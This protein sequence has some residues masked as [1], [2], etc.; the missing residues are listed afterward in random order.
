[1]LLVLWEVTGRFLRSGKF[2]AEL[3]IYEIKIADVPPSNDSN[4][5]SFTCRRNVNLSDIAERSFF[6]QQRAG[7]Q[8]LGYKWPTSVTSKPTV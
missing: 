6:N 4:C 7:E 8:I 3:P 2:T 5:E 1:M